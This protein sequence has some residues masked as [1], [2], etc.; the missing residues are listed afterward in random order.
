MAIQY[1]CNNSTDRI[2]IIAGEPIYYVKAAITGN[3]MRMELP[4]IDNSFRG[5]SIGKGGK[6]K[7]RRS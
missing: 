6:V 7:Y 4:E 3:T 1:G 5:G 2:L